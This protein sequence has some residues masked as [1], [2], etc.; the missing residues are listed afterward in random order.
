MD[1]RRNWR[2]LLMARPAEP[3]RTALL[4][5]G[6]KLL[7][8][9][10]SPG[11]SR[12]SANAVVAE[13]KMSKGAFFH[14]F[15]TR[16]DFVLELHARFHAEAWAAIVAAIDSMVPGAERI[17]AGIVAYLDFCLSR[18][19]AKV[20]LFEAR[21]DCD[22]RVRVSEMNEHFASFMEPDLRAA[23]WATPKETSHLAV[24]AIAE[25]VL[26]EKDQGCASRR[27]RQ[28]LRALLILR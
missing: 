12:L 1:D 3:G 6:T 22:L 24:A 11:W 21:A 10:A 7:A 8:A 25:V 23:G 19:D 20:F 18:G 27:H 28:A 26:I 2:G 14:H 5:A 9:E 4:D 15:P 13:A 16:R 17:V